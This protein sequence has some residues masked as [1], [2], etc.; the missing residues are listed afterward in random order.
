MR[1]GGKEPGQRPV[2]QAVVVLPYPGK[3]ACHK[4]DSKTSFLKFSTPGDM[5]LG[6]SSEVPLFKSSKD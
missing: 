4:K 1:R 5:P 6:Y 3:K 2:V